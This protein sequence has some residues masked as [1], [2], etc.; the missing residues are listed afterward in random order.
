MTLSDGKVHKGTCVAIAGDNLGSHNIGGFNEY[1][2]RSIYFCRFCDIDIKTFLTNPLAK[3]SASTFESY[4]GHVQ[5]NVRTNSDSSAGITFDSKLNELYFF[6]V[7]Q[8]GLP[9]C[10]GHDLF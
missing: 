8:P 7:C 10:I 4:N 9:P 1:F 2:S 3:A 5:Q 6:N